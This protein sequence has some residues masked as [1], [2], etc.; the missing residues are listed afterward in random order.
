L[1]GISRDF[2][3]FLLSTT[4]LFLFVGLGEWLRIKDYVSA[5]SSR[6]FVH[7]LVGLFVVVTPY[8]F[9][10]PAFIYLLAGI[11]VLF[12]LI[13]LRKGRLHGMHGIER[14]SAGTVTFPLVLIFALAV[15]WTM[16]ATRI[17]ALQ[18]AFLILA[19]SDPLASYVGSTL[20][21]PGRYTLGK[22][23]KSWIGSLAFL[24]SAF[25]IIIV[26]LYLFSETGR[27]EWILIDIF[28]ISFLVA[29]VT[30]AV[31]AVSERGWDNFFIVVA[32]VL[33]L[34]FYRETAFSLP[35]SLLSITVGLAFGLITYRLRF[36]DASGAV[37]GALLATTLVLMG[38]WPWIGPAL[39]FF[40]VASLLSKAL[41]RNREERSGYDEK[42]HV[43]DAAQVYANGGIG[44]L[45][46]LAFSV[47]PHPVMYWGFLGAFAA[48]AADTFAT[49]I[50]ML[51]HQQPRLVLSGR[52]V[53]RGTSGAVSVFGTG[54]SILGAGCVAAAAWP[55]ID[56]YVSTG[57][58]IVLIAFVVFAGFCS[59]FLDSILGA[60]VQAHYRDADSGAET[61][62]A[63]TDDKKNKLIRGRAWM[64]NDRVNL[65]ATLFGALL[66]LMGF[67]ITTPGH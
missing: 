8:L 28:G 52:R 57:S 45:F 24:F 7:L 27:P 32:A 22:N 60:T 21:H 34:V 43:R 65:A 41:R 1:P 25:L 38:G 55:F 15:C 11:F 31:E 36:L 12:N 9:V 30:C 64:N 39:T 4:G 40:L 37:A 51:S 20:D 58:G 46:L 35:D 10:K 47:F 59:S 50:G 13:A 23:Q 3:A 29:V 49:E 48:A 53:P 19:I 5:E 18:I 61:E 67:I 26:G 56:S 17:F 44:W 66:A 16:D 14:P 6:R 33:L 2:I 42:G 54:G 63:G 62:R